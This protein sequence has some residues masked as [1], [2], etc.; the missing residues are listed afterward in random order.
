MKS[1][2]TIVEE[3]EKLKKQVPK[4]F[5]DLMEISGLGP[6]KI[7]K[8]YKKLNIK[9]VKDLQKAI[10]EKTIEKLIIITTGYLQRHYL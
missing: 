1:I 6:K 4:G 10:K 7:S 2:E 9:T 5:Y 8:L 3:F